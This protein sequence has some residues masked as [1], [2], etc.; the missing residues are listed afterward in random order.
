LLLVTA[1]AD[2]QTAVRVPYIRVFGRTYLYGRKVKLPALALL[3]V[4][5]VILLPFFR[6]VSH[7]LPTREAISKICVCKLDHLGDLL[8]LTPFLDAVRRSLPEAK[9]TLV[10]GSWCRELAD[11][12]RRGGL[13]DDLVCYTPF[14]LNKTKANVFVRVTKSCVELVPALRMLR[15]RRF[16]LFVDMRPYFP[17][18]WFLA[19]L[20]GA[21]LR[22]GFGLRGMADTFHIIVPYSMSKRLGQLYLDALPS[23]TGAGLIYRKPILPSMQQQVA[24]ANA[25]RLPSRYLA[26]QLSSRERAR[27]ITSSLWENII[28]SLASNF[29][30]VLL[31]LADDQRYPKIEGRTDVVSLIGKTTVTDFLVIIEG[32]V[33]VVSVDSFAAH[34]GIAYSRTVAVLMVE[35]YSQHRSYPANNPNLGL[36]P[37]LDGVEKPVAK[38][39]SIHQ[40]EVGPKS[41]PTFSL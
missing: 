30:I 24:P 6:K 17:C 40:Q 39:F 25:F 18:A 1:I 5:D 2:K 16:D 7:S 27:N 22:A 10:V 3:A 33:G 38:F 15:R 21:K 12:L 8:M 28:S 32:S 31:G 36:F 19:M 20:S 37:G 41:A 14:S 34:V 11:V 13:I 35:P 29:S 4:R 26:V 9:I 23:I